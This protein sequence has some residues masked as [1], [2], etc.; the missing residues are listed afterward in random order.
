MS[1]TCPYCGNAAKL[2]TGRE[3]YAHRPELASGNYWQCAPCDAW[4][5]CHKP[6]LGYGDGTRPLGRLANESLRRAKARAHA[7]F[8]PIWESGK[9]TRSQAYAWLADALGLAPSETHMG[10]FDEAT[11]ARV[12]RLC[13]SRG[14]LAKKSFSVAERPGV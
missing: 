3:I 4:V 8:D 2:V 10:E 1:V 14:N 11:C 7:A 9:L 12:V 5:G 6:N 13:L